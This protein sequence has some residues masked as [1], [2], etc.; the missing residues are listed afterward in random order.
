[1]A[2]TDIQ[3]LVAMIADLNKGVGSLGGRMDALIGSVSK[4]EE[5]CAARKPVCDE[6][7]DSVEK[8]QTVRKAKLE[9]EGKKGDVAPTR[10]LAWQGWAIIALMTL[11]C[12]EVFLFLK[13]IGVH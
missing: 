10:Q 9:E 8:F 5:T 2:P 6:R 12:I 7:L 11:N 4:L 3:S 13:Y 1:M